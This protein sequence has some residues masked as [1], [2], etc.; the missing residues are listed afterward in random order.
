MLKQL[1]SVLVGIVIG[2]VATGAA[3][4]FDLVDDD[5]SVSTGFCEDTQAWYVAQAEFLA[6]TN[7]PNAASEEGMGATEARFQATARMPLPK[8][9][10]DPEEDLRELLFALVRAEEEWLSSLTTIDLALGLPG[11]T[12]A[13]QID[14][15]RSEEERRIEMNN[16]LRRVSTELTNACDFEP[17]PVYGF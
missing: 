2:V 16:L 8:A 15:F 17:L 4:W 6:Q 10:S 13:Q 14:V 9:D 11:L 1:V 5:L 7:Q 12:P 3:F